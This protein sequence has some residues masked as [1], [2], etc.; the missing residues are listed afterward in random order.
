MIAARK[1]KVL[2]ARAVVVRALNPAQLRL[3][4]EPL[5]QVAVAAVM[6]AT[7]R[8]MLLPAAPASSS[9]S[10]PYPFNLS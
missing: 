9:S 3:L 6:V 2:A 5:T 10:T 7:A 8:Q 1:R 4:P